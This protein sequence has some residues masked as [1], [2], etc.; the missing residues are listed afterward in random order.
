[1]KKRSLFCALIFTFIC[2][3]VSGFFSG[4]GRGEP[5][6]TQVSS[7]S[8]ASQMTIPPEKNE[9]P[10]G[11]VASCELEYVDGS[12]LFVDPT[13]RLLK[14]IDVTSGN[15]REVSGRTVYGE[16][17]FEDGT[18]WFSDGVTEELVSVDIADG[19]ETVWFSLPMSRGIKLG[20]VLIFADERSWGKDTAVYKYDIQKG[21][22][23]NRR[24]TGNISSPNRETVQ[25]G[26][27]CLWYISAKTGKSVVCSLD[28][29]DFGVET[30]FTS[31]GENGVFELELYGWDLYFADSGKNV[32]RVRDGVGEAEE[33]LSGALRVYSVSSEG[34]FYQKSYGYPS[35][36]YL[37][38]NAGRNVD[39]KGGIIIAS[40]GNRSLFRRIVDGE[41]SLVMVKYPEDTVVYSR[42]CSV[43]DTVTN[44]RYVLVFLNESRYIYFFDLETGTEEY[45]DMPTLERNG[46]SLEEYMADTTGL[47]CP[48][49]VALANATDKEIADT[50]VC[51]LGRNDRY[52]L[53]L[54]L[55][56]G[57]Y[58]AP[59]DRFMP[60]SVKTERT[61]TGEDSVKYGLVYSFYAPSDSVLLP[62][63]PDMLRKGSLSLVR[64]D[65]F[66][67]VDTNAS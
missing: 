2:V 58:V 1:M 64:E 6:D 49:L 16:F 60:M 18:V 20:N 63:L 45:F 48:S 51:A 26:S 57:E 36:L 5:S 19:T 35:K 42:E 40:W 24:L 27:E 17:I 14:L 28:Y 12:V 23:E 21:S 52:T 32:Y 25:F 30:V 43:F 11:P 33:F 22:W 15:S 34:I 31:D 41:E 46:V 56:E 50:F 54:L 10:S 7:E 3:S 47:S 39:V 65:G 62:Y 67:K 61:V 8:T 38:N 66:W 37:G 4:C 53:D 55:A 29:S 59:F 44:G 9:E 13:D